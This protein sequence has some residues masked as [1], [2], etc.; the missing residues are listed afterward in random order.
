M[1]KKI[2]SIIMC[3]I[4]IAIT[5]PIVGTVPSSTSKSAVIQKPDRLLF[6]GY[7]SGTTLVLWGGKWLSRCNCRR[8]RIWYE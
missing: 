5:L 7:S 4:L 6:L 2:I 1:K 8:A 3:M